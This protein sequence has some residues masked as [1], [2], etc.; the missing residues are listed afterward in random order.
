MIELIFEILGAVN[1]VTAAY[2]W[3]VDRNDIMTWLFFL[4]SSVIMYINA[5]RYS[6]DNE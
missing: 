5:I 4:F 3:I 1:F 2:Y 6:K